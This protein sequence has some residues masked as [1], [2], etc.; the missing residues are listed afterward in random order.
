MSGGDAA[1]VDRR[2]SGKA[3]ELIPR[4]RPR[5]IRRR[6]WS[7]FWVTLVLVATLLAFLIWYL[8][9]FAKKLGGS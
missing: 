3:N 9:D 7:I 1:D 5:E 2:S 8:Y 4:M 6:F